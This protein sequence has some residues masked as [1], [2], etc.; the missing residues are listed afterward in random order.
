MNI[1]IYT[2][3]F[4]PE[5]SG[6]SE[7][8]VIVA[9]ELGKLGH[10]VRI[11]A[12]KY[13]EKDYKKTNLKKQFK[14]GKNVSIKRLRS[15]GLNTG[16]GQGKS[17]IPYL[18]SY[19]DLKKFNP[20]VIHVNV[21]TGSAIEGI[22]CSKL[23]KKPL[24]GTNHS[25]AAQYAIYS[26]IKFNFVKDIIV[27]YVYS[28][29]NKCDVITSPSKGLLDDMIESGV[30]KPTEVV[31]AP[32]QIT[33]IKET[34]AQLRKKYK[35]DGFIVHYSGSLG[36]EKGPD[37]IVKAIALAKKQIPNI[38]LFVTGTGKL[39]PYLDELVKELNLE[40]NVKFFGFVTGKKYGEV[41]KMSDVFTIMTESETQNMGAMKAY[42]FGQPVISSYSKEV[43]KYIKKDCGFLIPRDEKS[44]AKKI[45]YY[46]KNPEILKKH[47]SNGRKFVKQF[48]SEN[49]TKKWIKLYSSLIR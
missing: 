24:I 41:Y 37:I 49:I 38:K 46:Y 48:S 28:I 25:R 9:K 35:T 27:K 6:V 17:A 40:D 13:R 19:R 22:I 47:G 8:I 1:A 12:P 31:P 10:K 18:S 26:P 2:D 32:V 3:I 15:I 34:K 45:I 36:E 7:S 11:Y 29:Y 4:Y 42:V 43:E 44:L 39:R 23:L 5:L 30:K 33:K 20:D 21:P 14:I 16:T